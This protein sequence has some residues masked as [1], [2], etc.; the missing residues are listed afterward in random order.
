MF[1][2]FC[3]IV[4]F[5]HHTRGFAFPQNEII[6]NLPSLLKDL[7][8]LQNNGTDSDNSTEGKFLL[9]NIFLFSNLKRV[10]T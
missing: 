8:L 6:Q 10:E 5:L 7:S 1:K 2:Y 4:V 3:L 9:Y